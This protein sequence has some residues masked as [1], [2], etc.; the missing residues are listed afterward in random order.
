MT[1]FQKKMMTVAAAGALTAV[2]A[3]PA[4]AFENEFH[5]SFAVKTFVSNFDGSVSGFNTATTWKEGRKTN[6]YTEQRTRIQYIAKASDDLKLVTH[7]EIN[8]V[9]GNT[10]KLPAS[11][12]ASK[13][14][15]G[16]D[17]D[18]INIAVKHAYLDFNLGKALNVKAGAQAYRDTLKGL[19]VDADLPMAL[20][21]YKNGGYT[22]GLGYSR[23]GDN[24]VAD[25]NGNSTYN[26]RLNSDLYVF[27]NTYAFSKDTRVSFSYYLNADNFT[28]GQE[29]KVNT[30][31][32][33]AQTKIGALDLSGFAAMQAGYQ[34][35]AGGKST[36]YSGWAANVAAK[37]KAGSGTAKTTMLFVS[38][39]NT[40]GAGNNAHNKGW[41]TLSFDGT[42]TTAGQN[43]Y[44]ESG[45][46]LLVRNTSAGGT[47]TDTY[48]RKPI[49]NVALAT[50]GYNAPLTDKLYV[51]GN[52]GF[53]WVP[54]SNPGAIGA[55][56]NG[57]DFMGTEMNVE[58]GYK[59]YKNLTLKAQAAYVVMG[60]HY[61]KIYT[62]AAGGKS[63]PANPFTMRLGAHYSF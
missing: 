1:K 12:Q 20:V 44:N 10:N 58:T 13:G 56:A 36:V 53:A 39:N 46:M 54:A 4:M 59:L 51:D 14:S 29:K 7:F 32:L 50:L 35:Q 38:G 22:L 31:G 42:N 47:S 5:G 48:F 37:M 33:A 3:L 60:P 16:I 9:W 45:M 21:T 57:G 28:V 27:D 61:S 11:S 18:T 52:V 19:Y 41:Q 30:F 55:A 34:K 49:T 23:F 2:T 63:D 17:T 43:S 25:N 15:G 62:N 26:G 6:N 40:N 24:A 8:S